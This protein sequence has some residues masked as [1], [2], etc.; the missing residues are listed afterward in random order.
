M[1]RIAVIGVVLENPPESQDEFN[2]IV[3]DYSG[4]IKGRMGLPFSEHNIGVISLVVIADMDKINSFTG[5]LGKMPDVSVKTVVSK[6]E[7]I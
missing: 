5:K 6:R 1:K 2:S 4:I 7:I 3:S